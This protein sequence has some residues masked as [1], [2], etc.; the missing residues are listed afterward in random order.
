[1]KKHNSFKAL[2][3]AVAMFAF[4]GSAF[5]QVESSIFFN[6]NMPVGSFAKD[7]SMYNDVNLGNKSIGTDAIFGIGGTY[8]IGYV[9]DIQIGLIEPFAEAGFNWNRISGD[10]RDKYDAY[11]GRVPNYFNIPLMLGINYRYDKL[12]ETFVPYGE[13]G[14]GYDLFF[15]NGEGKDNDI[16]YQLSYKTNGGFA[17][18]I[19]A[20]VIIGQYFSVGLSF[21]SYGNHRIEYTNGTVDN[22]AGI[23]YDANLTELNSKGEAAI[24]RR[25][26]NNLTIKL[27][28]HF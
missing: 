14:L 12:S 19:G 20:G 8:R 17:W 28:F 1:M 25:S 26:F 22:H 27:G 3:V 10:N 21:V 23:E 24:V 5:A 11:R 15:T 9:F 7:A 13:F 4:G 18:Q 16:A 2:L 6:M